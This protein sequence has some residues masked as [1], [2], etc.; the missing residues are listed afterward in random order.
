MMLEG[1]AGAPTAPLWLIGRDYGIVEARER[2]PFLGQAGYVL[3]AALR[4]AGIRRES[5]FIDNVVRE[6]P[7]GNDWRFHL[8]GAVPAGVA[9]LTDLLQRHAPRVVVPFGNEAFRAVLH[10]DPDDA[11]GLPPITDARGYVFEAPWSTPERPCSI[12]PSVHPAAMLREWVPWRPLFDCDMQKVRRE[13]TLLQEGGGARP[14]RHVTVVTSAAEAEMLRQAAAASELLAVDIEN[15]REELY[16]CGFATS[17]SRAWVVPAG[18]PWQW[19]LIQELCEGPTPKVLQNGQYDRYCLWR[20]WGIELRMQRLDTMLLW[21]AMQP[22]LAGAK[23]RPRSGRGG[24][25]RTIKSLHFFASLYTRDAWWKDYAFE[26]EGE[27]YELCGRDCCITLD[28]A[29]QMTLE[30]EAT[31]GR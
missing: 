4:Q 8:P 28:V 19:Q 16:C 5:C 30:M 17:P 12:I 6:Q 27:R 13:L 10:G 21:H 31:H 22:E 15:N 14:K 23:L 11:H 3:N 2:A 25:R 18:E 7:K 1:S 20:Y 26:T 24:R 9:R 29:N